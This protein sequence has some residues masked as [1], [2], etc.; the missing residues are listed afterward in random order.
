MKKNVPLPSNVVRCIVRGGVGMLG[1]IWVARQRHLSVVFRVFGLASG[2]DSVS[3]IGW[4]RRIAPDELGAVA[5]LHH[6]PH[7]AG[8]DVLLHFHPDRV[9]HAMVAAMR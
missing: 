8:I 3:L 5:K 9:D 1:A 6:Q 7:R 4:L 2:G